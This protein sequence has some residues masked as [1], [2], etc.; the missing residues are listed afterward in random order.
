MTVV[1]QVEAMYNSCTI[2]STVKQ[3]AFRFTADDLAVLDAVQAKLGMVNRTDVLR[4]AI[5]RL[6]QLEG[7]TLPKPPK[8]RGVNH[9]A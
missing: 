9:G 3:T 4:L 2:M 1:E 6:A 7:V 8:K 5:R